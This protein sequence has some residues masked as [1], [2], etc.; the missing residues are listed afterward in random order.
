MIGMYKLNGGAGYPVVFNPHEIAMEKVPDP[1]LI[2]HVQLPPQ[3]SKDIITFGAKYVESRYN[4]NR[5]YFA[6]SELAKAYHT[7]SYKALDIEHEL[8]D[9]CG[10]IYSSLYIDRDKGESLNPDDLIAMG[11]TDLE[12]LT[13]DVI[14]GGVVYVDRF[15]RLEGPVADKAYKISMETYFDTFDILL[16]NGVRVTLEEAEA[17]GLGLFVEQLM[18]EFETMEEFEDAHKLAVK[19][20]DPSDK[21]KEKT[22]D[23]YKYLK[24]ILFSGGGLVLNPAC[25][26]CHILST[27]RDEEVCGCEDKAAASSQIK[28]DLFH[29]DLSGFDPSVKMWREGAG[30]KPLVH[31]VQ[32]DLHKEDAAGGDSLDDHVLGPFSPADQPGDFGPAMCT[33]Y[34]PEY[35]DDTGTIKRN[36]CIYASEVCTTAGDR[37]FKECHRWYRQGENYV[38]DTRSYRDE[39]YSP[40]DEGPDPVNPPVVEAEETD[41]TGDKRQQTK[42]ALKNLLDS[43]RFFLD[44]RSY[45]VEDDDER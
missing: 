16:E 6:N 3:T 13:I 37:S 27:S 14:V 35:A 20:Y 44:A 4:L 15:P 36:W 17:L 21:N 18:G 1:G 39:N 22:M 25:P 45:T 5:A 10:H 29:V 8:L 40:K 32:V 28:S 41:N 42:K 43:F 7:I 2:K 9:I 38:Y 24:G 19:G 11:E 31:Q 33:S 12:R 34:K 26:S 30:G 23:I